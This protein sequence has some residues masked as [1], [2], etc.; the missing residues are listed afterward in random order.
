MHILICSIWRLLIALLL[1]SFMA[2]SAFADGLSKLGNSCEKSIESANIGQSDWKSTSIN[3]ERFYKEAGNS[4]DPIQ[5]FWSGIA[6]GITYAQQGRDNEANELISNSVKMLTKT[7]GVTLDKIL[8][9]E[10]SKSELIPM[11]E[12]LAEAL[13]MEE[14]F[15]QS[16][17]L[18]RHALNLEE[19]Q[20]G[21][22]HRNV[23]MR[24]A[25][26]AGVLSP[27]GRHEEAA[28]QL[29]RSVLILEKADG[30]ESFSTLMTKDFLALEYEILGQYERS[31]YLRRSVLE[32]RTKTLGANHSLVAKSL[33]S[34]AGLLKLTGRRNE[35]YPLYQRILGIEEHSLGLNNPEVAAALS[36]IAERFADRGEFADAERFLLR[37]MS[38]RKAAFGER[39]K[40]VIDS[41]RDI[42]SL[43]GK[44]V[45]NNESEAVYKEMLALQEAV[46]GRNHSDIA[47]TI[48]SLGQLANAQGRAKEADQ[49]FRRSLKIRES[50]FGK[51]GEPVT[52]SLFWIA[53]ISED[54]GRID[55]A[56]AAYRRSLSIIEKNYGISHP[57]VADHLL[58]LAD[59]L[60]RQRKPEM[61]EP[62]INRA[63]EIRRRFFGDKHPDVASAYV[64][65]DICFQKQKKD[66]DALDALRNASW[67]RGKRI[68]EGL[69]GPP[70]D[71]MRHHFAHHVF[72]VLHSLATNETFDEAFEI[73]QLINISNA[74]K[75]ISNMAIRSGNVGV[76][77][78][79]KTMQ[80]A[81][82]KKELV[83]K[84]LLSAASLSA[85]K[86]DIESEK[87]SRDE[88]VFLDKKISELNAELLRRFPE[89]SELTKP[90]PLTVDDTQLLLNNDEA[91][92]AWYV[93]E[94][95]TLLFFIRSNRVAFVTI[96]AG[97]QKIAVLVRRLRTAVEIPSTGDLLPFP[98][99]SANELYQLLFG[100]VEKELK[101]V[102]HLIMVP[103]GPLQ[104][105]SFGM[106]KVGAGET[107]NESTPW[108][109]RRY[110][111]TTLPA[112]TSLQALRKFA[113]T[114]GQ[115]EPFIGFGDP[116]LKG[117]GEGTRGVKIARLFARGLIADTRA[118][119]EMQ[120][121][122]AT[123]DELKS[124][125]KSLKA[126][127]NSIFLRQAATESAVKK[128]PLNKYRT[129]AFATHG[130]MAGEFMGVQEPALVLTPPSEGSEDDD[131]LLTASEVAG[132]KL[133]ADWVILSACNTAA[134]D[135]TPGA[136][137]FSGLTKAFF[138][139]GARTLLVSHW[140]V[141]S[142]SAM[143]LTTR[144]F[145]E[146]EK[147]ATKSE[148][149][150]RSMMA[151]ADEP[152]TA[153]P[154][155]W[156]P[157]VVVGE[158]AR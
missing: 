139:A 130:I 115:R 78:L 85:D 77:D 93:M 137:G 2:S 158:G 12:F 13:R 123:A 25:Q 57:R 52:S 146:I 108:L 73:A 79:I 39:H 27:Q 99:E 86:R 14:R 1:P 19:T 157:F 104:S 53:Q 84:K 59:F 100:Q 48:D 92:L 35:A 95:Q 24:L 7:L 114:P 60:V 129:V 152:E 127:A 40:I 68:I 153:H 18:T 45:K 106:L 63:I 38:I 145:E 89:F 98:D 37:A 122:P 44:Q 134:P 46:L 64:S 71:N 136:Q 131:G 149:L 54:Q 4:N 150:R 10:L 90:F 67:V 26:L 133:D 144:M 125:A 61:A 15:D 111:L 47:N 76:A 62:L 58:Y 97:H 31:E 51:Y 124:I 36:D 75:A 9:D 74:G 3:C 101:D 119:S 126:D 107:A 118:V 116:D 155:Y 87:K 143:K 91:M 29:E 103:D 102:S 156:A 22:D 80:D 147:G 81:I 17:K 70:N 43:Y 41:L 154:A 113:K 135:G 23:G 121:L 140:A 120:P 128:M 50:V 34:L 72:R 82:F 66:R 56:E 88:L 94:N 5:L 42:A 117:D 49:L 32:V 96:D 110:A 109:A 16:E 21:K 65:L 33:A 55:N 138:Y 148:A 8:S 20:L 28:R 142:N 6:L 141:E 151:L 11:W 132:L 83:E 112:I 105:L 69:D 30:Q